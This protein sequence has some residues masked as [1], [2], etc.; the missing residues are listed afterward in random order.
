[1]AG[2]PFLALPVASGFYRSLAT[3]VWAGLF[4]LPSK[5]HAVCHMPRGSSLQHSLSVTALALKGRLRQWC[6][7]SSQP[8]AVSFN[9]G[10]AFLTSHNPVGL[11]TRSGFIVTERGQ[12][13]FYQQTANT[14]SAHFI[15]V[16]PTNKLPFLF[17]CT[18]RCGGH[19]TPL[20]T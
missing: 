6:F 13:K 2:F 20:I 8:G 5:A 17:V 12:V 9:R 3:T 11:A 4:I 1:M 19:I 16:S 14:F 18:K 7:F 15:S 10:A